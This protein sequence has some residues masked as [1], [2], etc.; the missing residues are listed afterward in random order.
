MVGMIK[1]VLGLGLVAVVLAVAI[2]WFAGRDDPDGPDKDGA[3]PQE[4]ENGCALGVYPNTDFRLDPDDGGDLTICRYE[5]QPLGDEASHLL[6]ESR[7]LTREES[8]SVRKAIR[9]APRGE[10]EFTGCDVAPDDGPG[11][12]FLLFTEGHGSVAFWV[13]NAVCGDNGVLAVNAKG[14]PVNKL[15][16]A[17]VLTALGSP[18]G[19]LGPPTG[20]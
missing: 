10:Q 15:D 11:E 17:Q 5:L 9:R 13:Y 1:R 6:D 8:A 3:G 12:F 18:Y 4:D 2:T 16:T 14:K 19:P 20:R 7:A